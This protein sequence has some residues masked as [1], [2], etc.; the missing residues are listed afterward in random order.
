MEIALNI[1][2]DREVNIRFSIDLELR[3]GVIAIIRA[4]RGEY[5]RSFT[6]YTFAK[7]VRRS[8]QRTHNTIFDGEMFRCLD[9]NLEFW[10]FVFSDFNRFFSRLKNCE[11]AF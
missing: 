1:T 8:H 4:R 7:G 6:F 10:Q 5:N 2:A 3:R 9:F 11:N